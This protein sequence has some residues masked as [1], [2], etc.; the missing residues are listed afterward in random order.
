MHSSS[1]TSTKAYR[2]Q[3]NGGT[4]SRSSLL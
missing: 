1:M 3:T 4:H 2:V